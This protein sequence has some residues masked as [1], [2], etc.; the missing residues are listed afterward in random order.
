MQAYSF[1]CIGRAVLHDVFGILD[2]CSTWTVVGVRDLQAVQVRE[3]RAV[4]STQSED[5]G[6]LPSFQV[7]QAGSPFGNVLLLFPCLLE[8]A[9]YEGFS[10]LLFIPP[11]HP[12]PPPI[13]ELWAGEHHIQGHVLAV[14]LSWLLNHWLLRVALMGLCSISFLQTFES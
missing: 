11:P 2:S 1:R 8:L 5:D 13:V 3:Q 12:T 6:L 10:P 9:L 14:C 7:A 4:A